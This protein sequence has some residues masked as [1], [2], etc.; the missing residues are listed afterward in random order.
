MNDPNFAQ[1]LQM[2]LQANPQMNIN[3]GIMNPGMYNNINP[4]QIQNFLNSMGIYGANPFNFMNIF[5][6][7]PQQPQYNPSSNN[8][9][10]N[11]INVIFI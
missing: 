3:P 10:L 5:N 6:P 2:L 8:N 11:Y 7:Q 1:F 4:E 9:S